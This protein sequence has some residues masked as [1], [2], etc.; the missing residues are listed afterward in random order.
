MANR[1][2]QRR[3]ARFRRRGTP[4]IPALS[5]QRPVRMHRT[6]RIATARTVAAAMTSEISTSLNSVRS[7][8]TELSLAPT[9]CDLR[10]RRIR[11]MVALQQGKHHRHLVSGHQI[12]PSRPRDGREKFAR[13]AAAPR[14]SGNVPR[15]KR[16]RRVRPQFEGPRKRGGNCREFYLV[17]LLRCSRRLG[18]G[19]WSRLQ[20]SLQPA[21]Q[22]K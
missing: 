3:R 17:S 22:T 4:C 19:L 1:G 8:R 9:K 2:W 21:G 12:P 18:R 6:L 11:E 5:R 10:I 16:F 20:K 15:H 7:T 13:D 14:F